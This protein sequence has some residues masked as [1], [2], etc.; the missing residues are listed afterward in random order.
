MKL[1]SVRK[2]FFPQQ[3]F[4]ET[5]YVPGTAQCTCG[6]GMNEIVSTFRSLPSTAGRQV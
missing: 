2:L 3:N 1:S 6:T 5:H 4:V